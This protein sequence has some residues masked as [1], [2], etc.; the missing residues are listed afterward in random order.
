MLDSLKIFRLVAQ[1][2]SFT[3]AAKLA[4][5]TRPAVSQQIKQLELH[6]GMELLTRSTRQVTVTPAGA[7]L[8]E[9]VD[10]VMQ[11]VDLLEATMAA[12]HRDQAARITVAASTLPGESLLPRALAAFREER[13]DVEVQLRVANT[14]AVLHW[15]R[16]GQVDF[17]LV[18]QQ[19]D[20]ADLRCQP[21]VEDEILLAIPPGE[22]LP[23]PLPLRRLLQLPLIMR[24]CGS[25]TR[26]T[27]LEALLAHGISPS[28]LRV[29]AEMGSP[30]AVKSAV[31]A[32]IGYA[33]VSAANLVPGE[34]ATVQVEGLCLKRSICAC[35]PRNREPSEPQ[36]SLL[37]RLS[38]SQ[39]A[40][41]R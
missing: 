19:V 34:L 3:K 23:N 31:R 41:H 38:A 6:F 18:G 7:A 2:A 5:L 17:G 11:E 9:H 35:W 4:G 39:P 13:G 10:R 14:E 28:C 32:G 37:A 15:V 20:D 29:I 40:E 1:H 21:V 33:F 22:S 16:E 27:V 8:L 36:R 12:I 30:E 24:E 26:S 25:A